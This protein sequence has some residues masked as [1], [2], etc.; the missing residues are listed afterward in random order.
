MDTLGET[1]K[2]SRKSIGFTL[3]QVEEA[4]NISNAYLSQL[5]NDKIKNPSANILYK[6]SNL[7]RIRLKSLLAAAGIISR[8]DIQKEKK[9]ESFAKKVAF[10]AEEMTKEEKEL[11]LDYLE[12]IKSKRKSR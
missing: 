12:Y 11:V 4:L 5:E 8:V 10:S 2:K 7:Y 9:S 3:V 1:L 6:L